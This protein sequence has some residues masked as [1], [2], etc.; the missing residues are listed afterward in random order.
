MIEKAKAKINPDCPQ[1]PKLPLI[2]LRVIYTNEDY[3]FNSIR[4][5][6]QYAERVRKWYWSLSE[7]V[8]DSNPKFPGT[9]CKSD[10]LVE[11]QFGQKTAQ[12]GTDPSRRRCYEQSV[13]K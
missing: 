1:Q 7:Y 10:G 2:R 9:G 6:Q 3:I 5:G 13:R 8:F 4:F 11:I 12:A